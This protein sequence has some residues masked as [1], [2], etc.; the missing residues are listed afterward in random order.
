[1]LIFNL[2]ILNPYSREPPRLPSISRY[3]VYESFIPYKP[4]DPDYEIALL[5]AN[6]ISAFNEIMF[7]ESF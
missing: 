3:A 2:N 5:G 4:S 1:M 7:S 6:N